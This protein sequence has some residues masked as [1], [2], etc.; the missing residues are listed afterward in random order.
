MAPVSKGLCR[1]GSC[2]NQRKDEFYRRNL[3][4]IRFCSPA[5]LEIIWGLQWFR[6]HFVS[7]PVVL[8]MEKKMLL[9]TG[10][11]VRVLAAAVLLLHYYLEDEARVGKQRDSQATCCV[12]KRRWWWLQGGKGGWVDPR[13]WCLRLQFTGLRWWGKVGNPDQWQD[14]SLCIA[15]KLEWRCNGTRLG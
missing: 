1:S 11:T 9:E 14:M 13:C 8:A 3:K 10:G 4:D 6:R 7:Q 12:H 2:E 5:C 15:D